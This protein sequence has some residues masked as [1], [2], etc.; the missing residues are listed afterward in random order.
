MA[1]CSVGKCPRAFTALREH[2]TLRWAVVGILDVRGHPGGIPPGI[3]DSGVPAWQ[4][5]VLVPVR[6]V[7]RG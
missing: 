1:A 2:G 5:V 4:A 7:R 6:F 3:T